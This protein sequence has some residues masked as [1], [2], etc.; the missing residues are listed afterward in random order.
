VD[1]GQ[2][3]D[4]HLVAMS[5][6]GDVV[7]YSGTDPALPGAF[8]LKGV[9]WVGRLPPGRNVASTFG[10][11]L[12]ILSVVGCVPL[13][14]LVSGGLIR[15]PTIMAS[16][17]VANL[18][19]TLMTERGEIVGWSISIHPT[20][21]L[22]VINVPAVPGKVG[23][24]LTMSL[25]NHGWSQNVGIPI[26]CMESWHNK[27]FFGTADSRVGVNEGYVD[28]M[29]LDGTA[30]IAIDW[31]LL[32][33]YQSM[34]S[35]QKKRVHMVRPHFM[36]DGTQPGYATEARYDF[37][38]SGIGVVPTVLEPTPSP[39]D[40]ALWDDGIWDDSIGTAGQYGGTSGLGTHIAVV[41]RGSSTTQIT[42]VGMD[43]VLEQGGIF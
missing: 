10:G 34:G 22:L 32:T 21:N 4:D 37:N 31:S 18:F 24:Q 8:A 28:G 23:Q 17:K 6:G 26:M 29:K 40:G 41:L 42:L 25:A 9:W 30:P 3:I 38:L 33:S 27:L 15:D 2:G 14:K 16:G 11:D 20:D 36:T 19:N 39:W 35:A 13:S 5:R 12:F 43:V 1:G 7:I